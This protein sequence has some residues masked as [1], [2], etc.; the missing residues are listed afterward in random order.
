MSLDRDVLAARLL[1]DYDVACDELSGLTAPQR[2]ALTLAAKG[3]E[4]AAVGQMLGCSH[5]AV[6]TRLVKA[7][8]RLQC[9]MA[10]AI[11]LAA[12]AGWV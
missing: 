4:Y 12:K 1:H 11:A 2:E 9:S 6:R 5:G 8:S 3:F 7:T 10:E